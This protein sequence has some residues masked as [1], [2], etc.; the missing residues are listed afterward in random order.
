MRN[1]FLK[2]FTIVIS[3]IIGLVIF[4]YL[5]SVINISNSEVYVLAKAYI[6]ENKDVEERIGKVIDFGD[7]PYGSIGSENSIK[8]AQIN[9]KIIGEKAET[10]AQINLKKV[11]SI[12]DWEVV[13]L[14]LL[15]N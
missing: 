9:L 2:V 8:K 6:K 5:Y 10:D 13:N 7:L 4:V 12:N 11:N 14:I 1:K 3:T 15:N